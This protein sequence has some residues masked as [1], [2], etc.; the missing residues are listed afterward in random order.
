MSGLPTF[1]NLTLLELRGEFGKHSIKLLIKLL[2]CL[3]KLELL[4][5]CEVDDNQNSI[6]AFKVLN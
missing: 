5:F 3:P 2:E 1:E 4:H 6:S